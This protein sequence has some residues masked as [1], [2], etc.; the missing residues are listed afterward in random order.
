MSWKITDLA[1]VFTKE[2]GQS[3]TAGTV[4]V[5]LKRRGIRYRRSR[6]VIVSTDEQYYNLHIPFLEERL[7]A[8]G[9]RLAGVLN[10]TFKSKVIT[11][12]PKITIS[13]V[14]VNP[15]KFIEAKDAASHVGDMCQ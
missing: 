5:Y 11:T 15:K 2:F 12:P 4:S 13:D 9:L 14:P 1:E 3:I 10:E 8:G 6:E 7:I